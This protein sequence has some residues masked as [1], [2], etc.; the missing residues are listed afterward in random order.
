M[1]LLVHFKWMKSTLKMEENVL[2]LENRKAISTNNYSVVCMHIFSMVC[3][4]LI[5]NITMYI[6]YAQ[7]GGTQTLLILVLG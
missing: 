5:E 1:M 4:T 2:E 3:K 7:L 6:G